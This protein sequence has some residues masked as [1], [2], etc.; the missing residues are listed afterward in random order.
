[1][2]NRRFRDLIAKYTDKYNAAKSRLEKSLVV[3]EIFEEVKKIKGRFLKQAPNGQWYELDERQAKEKCGHAIRDAAS[4]AD[5][6]RKK[7][8]KRTKSNS[9]S[10]GVPRK[11]SSRFFQR[12]RSD[13]GMDTSMDSS[14]S[15]YGSVRRHNSMNDSSYSCS[16]RRGGSSSMRGYS[17]RRPE[18]SSAP[19]NDESLQL[20][21][22]VTHDEFEP[23]HVDSFEAHNSLNVLQNDD[24]FLRQMNVLAPEAAPSSAATT[25][26]ATTNNANESAYHQP[27]RMEIM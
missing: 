9:S 14:S 27:F 11:P 1:V 12:S 26:P 24:F 25:A 5:P 19:M 16:S 3:H 10:C 2:G 20:T 4:N 17:S 8:P 6:N 22:L 18:R 13:D 7:G 21:A 15:T 23:L